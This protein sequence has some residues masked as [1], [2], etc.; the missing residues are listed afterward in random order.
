[1]KK[2]EVAKLKEQLEIVN[3]ELQTSNK[4]LSQIHQQE[5]DRRHVTEQDNKALQAE[6][7]RLKE[8]EE[9]A[10][11]SQGFYQDDLRAQAHIAQEAQ[12]NYERELVKHAE[13]A[14]NVQQLREEI[15]TLRTE[16]R[17][18][19]TEAETA[20]AT[21][22]S[23]ESSWET[24]KS[25]Y[26][27]ELREVRARAD[28][29][30]KQNNILHQQFENVASQA[31]QIRQRTDSDL[32]ALESSAS[33][34]EVPAGKE[35]SI[36]GLREVIRYLRREKEIV[37][38]KHEMLQQENRRLKQQLDRTVTDLDETRVLLMSER[39]KEASA[40]TTS[41]QHQELLAKINE[42][43][44]LRESNVTLRNENERNARRAAELET[45]V[46]Q[47]ANQMAPLE[48]RVRT[49]QAEIESKD[50]QMRLLTEDNERWKNRNQQILQKYERIDPVELQNL[51]DQLATANSQKD[52]LET[53]L[54]DAILKNRAV[55]EAWKARLDK[56]VAG[57]KTRLDQNKEVIENLEAKIRD[58]ATETA[59]STSKV[60][61]VKA[62]AEAGKQE[63]NQQITALQSQLEELKANPPQGAADTSAWETE[64]QG[65]EE[66]L[67]QRDAEIARISNLARGAE[68][69]KVYSSPNNA[70]TQRETTARLTSLEEEVKS[71]KE[72]A[73]QASASG[74]QPMDQDFEQRVNEAVQ[75]RLSTDNAQQIESI[76]QGRLSQAEQEKQS[77]ITEAV[78]ANQEAADTKLAETIATKDK[79][80]ADLRNTA[81][82]GQVDT[83]IDARIAAAVQVRET[84]LKDLHDQEVKSAAEAAYRR[85]KQPSNDKIREGANK[86]AEKLVSE[87][88]E[89]FLEEQV[90]S[91]ASV[92]PEVLAKA[93]EEAQ[94]KKEDEFVEKLQKARDGARAEAEM[95]NKLTVSK[96]EKQVADAKAKLE[97][98]EKQVGSVAPPSVGNQPSAVQHPATMHSSPAQQ[99][100]IPQGRPSPGLPVVGHP[101]PVTNV[102]QQLQ[103]GRGAGIPRPGRGGNQQGGQRGGA[104]GG[105]GR[106]QQRLSGQHPSQQQQQQILQ[107]QGQRPAVNRPLQAGYPVVGPGQQQRRQSAQQGQSQLPRPAPGTNPAAAPFQPGQKRTRD[108]E[109]QGGQANQAAGQKRPRVANNAGGNVGNEGQS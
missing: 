60:E 80:L 21:L 44:L 27:R 19:R 73:A 54:Q 98:Y 104:L 48:E 81:R 42:L 2:A 85:F 55:A 78:R 34:E 99:Q 35:D 23:S 82:G 105:Q 86:L 33:T 36:E 67:K 46:S 91:G 10:Q 53:Q 24:Q 51:K 38:I 70:N 106:G 3:N 77:A 15:G 31:Q 88:W 101:N 64:K 8:V 103:A 95:R 32:T 109:V 68:R 29:L 9:K 28:D 89:K 97:V 13:A 84:E 108:D 93:V 76:V 4:E 94:K 102:L 37:D 52:E 39:E 50:D 40:A 14:Q 62:E 41:A 69:A 75:Q 47:L 56:A 61:A 26:E 57:A 87:R 20:T 11:L 22:Q 63:L 72:Q 5:E 45:K 30:V 65:L 25:E 100:Q 17:T 71:L 16:L 59:S 96:L 6:I 90:A 66:T 92:S 18:L 74:D 12:R 79:E 107:N 43:N 49:L 58:S 83:D 1:M 7:T